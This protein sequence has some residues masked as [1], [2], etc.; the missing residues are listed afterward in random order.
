MIYMFPNLATWTYKDIHPPSK[1]DKQKLRHKALRRQKSLDYLH[2]TFLGTTEEPLHQ[3]K[4]ALY[5]RETEAES[6]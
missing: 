3:G 6:K 2:S 1:M 4:A 5:T